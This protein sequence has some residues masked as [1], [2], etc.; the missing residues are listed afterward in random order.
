MRL[1]SD[2]APKQIGENC[3]PVFNNEVGESSATRLIADAIIRKDFHLE[4]RGI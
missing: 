1:R 4:S 3:D 2:K